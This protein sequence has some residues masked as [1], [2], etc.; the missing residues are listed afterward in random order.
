MAMSASEFRVA[1]TSPR[2]LSVSLASRGSDSALGT[3]TASGV[4]ATGDVL[5]LSWYG[6]VG[7]SGAGTLG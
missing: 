2:T 3:G 1:W 7:G 6:S 4:S 5:A